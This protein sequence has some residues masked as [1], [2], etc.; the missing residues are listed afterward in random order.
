M[1]VRIISGFAPLLLK[2][3]TTS[4]VAFASKSSDKLD[5]RDA[6][7]REVVQVRYLCYWIDTSFKMASM[8][9]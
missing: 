7:N 3:R 9:T 1:F 6:E 5:A 4:M 2:L 8:L